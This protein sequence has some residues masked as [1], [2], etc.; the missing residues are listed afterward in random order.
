VRFKLWANS[1]AVRNQ[2]L[3]YR[4][5]GVEGRKGPYDVTLRLGSRAITCAQA[6]NCSGSLAMSARSSV[7]L[8]QVTQLDAIQLHPQSPDTILPLSRI[9]S[10]TAE[11][12]EGRDVN[13]FH[14]E[15]EIGSYLRVPR[16][17]FSN[18]TG[19]SK[20][21]LS[22]EGSSGTRQHLL[23]RAA[24][25]YSVKVSGVSEHQR[26]SAATILSKVPFNPSRSRPP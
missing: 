19:Q 17:A 13:V 21:I 26:Q 12:L 11:S 18:Y 23:P 10:S 8:Q 16:N 6:A 15:E 9:L 3:S 14:I 22:Q 2:G 20:R 25:N 1:A 4:A 24:S 5:A 7:C